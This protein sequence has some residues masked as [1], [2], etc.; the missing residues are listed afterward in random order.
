LPIRLHPG[1][2]ESTIPKSTTN[3]LVRSGRRRFR[4]IICARATGDQASARAGF[5]R[6]GERPEIFTGGQRGAPFARSY[7][8]DIIKCLKVLEQEQQLPGNMTEPGREV[9]VDENHA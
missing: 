6:G 4:R 9:L 5:H 8:A 1:I 7:T 2:L 3:P